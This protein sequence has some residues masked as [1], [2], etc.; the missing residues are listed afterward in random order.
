LK[1]SECDGLDVFT[2]AHSS[3]AETARIRRVRFAATVEAEPNDLARPQ[4]IASPVAVSGRIDPPGDQDVFRL[5]L[6]K[7]DKRVIR[8][9]SRAL[10]RPLDPV[11]RI[12]DAGGKILA[13]SDDSGRNDRDLER[14]FTAPADGEY[15]LVV[16]DLNGRG[17]PRFAYLLS[18]LV[19]RPDFTLSLASDRF[20]LTPGKETKITV[21]VQ[22]KD[23]LAEPIEIV[24]EDLPAGITAR[25]VTS[26]PG[27]ASARS[28]N[29]ELSGGDTSRP[30]PFR[31]VGRTARDP[32]SSHAATAPI[33]GFDA[34]T[35]QPWLMIRRT[36]PEARK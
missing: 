23:G 3:L 31:I 34:R 25:P 13:E 14:S 22:R 16:R 6:R 10:G 28:V 33:P 15:R 21:A 36:G 26:K 11:L 9:E 32:R 29:L 7:D 4:A 35:E 30:G 1:V 24:A 2:A 27:D 20:D 12:L 5:A 19:A 18:V 8:V 17:G